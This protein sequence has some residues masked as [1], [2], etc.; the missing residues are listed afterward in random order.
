MDSLLD[1]NKLKTGALSWLYEMEML[2]TPTLQNNLQENILLSN[3]SIQ[4][5]QILIIEDFK[6]I[7]VF[8][9]LGWF[10][11][12]FKQKSI[13]SSVES[14][15]KRILPTFRVRVVADKSIFDLALKKVKDYYG[16]LNENNNT[17]FNDESISDASDSSELQETSNI[18]PDKEE[19]PKD[20]QQ[21]SDV[22][23]QSDLEIINKKQDPI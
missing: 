17:D 19:S 18:L 13:S 10:A 11:R 20:E 21:E 16:G 22:S 3:P 12:K 6:D 4:S 14:V 1:D 15:V 2:S 23:E 7:L 8:T 9:K 5:C